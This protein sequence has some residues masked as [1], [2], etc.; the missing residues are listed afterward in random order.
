M[1]GQLLWER[2]AEGGGF[3]QKAGQKARPDAT[4][5]A[6]TALDRLGAPPA[7]LRPHRSYLRGAQIDTGGVALD[8][9]ARALWPTPLALLAWQGDPQFAEPARR[10]AGFLLATSGEH[11][12]SDR[13]GDMGHDTSIRGWPWVAD[14]HSWIEPTALAVLALRG[15]GNGGHERVAEAVRMILD[16]QLPAG[17]WNYGNLRVFRNILHPLPESTGFALWALAGLAERG[18][19]E[20]S[21]GYLEAALEKV[22][23]PLS[24]GAGLTGLAAWGIVPPFAAEAIE[25]AASRPPAPEPAGTSDLAILGIAASEVET[26]R[27]REIR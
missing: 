25:A 16:R 24:L 7:S 22:R 2:Q 13:D 27:R 15:A 4:A 1:I 17:G 11:W 19:V 9:P 8:A 10:A 23:T 26:A 12:Q 21:L 3:A 6:V 18:H 20:A 5:W 14:T